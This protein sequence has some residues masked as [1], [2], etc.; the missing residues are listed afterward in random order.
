MFI[1]TE[2]GSILNTAHFRMFWIVETKTKAFV[3]AVSEYIDPTNKCDAN[4][5]I[6]ECDSREDAE[7]ALDSLSNHIEKEATLWDANVYKD[8]TNSYIPIS[9][10]SANRLPENLK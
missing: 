7:K 2:K 3:Q 4:Q 5:P 10:S 9:G 1:R 8:T 6:L